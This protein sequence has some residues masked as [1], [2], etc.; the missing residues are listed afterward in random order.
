M[1]R[2]I[3]VVVFLTTVLVGG[4]SAAQGALSN[5]T[6]AQWGCVGA[7]ALD[8]VVCVSNPLPERLPL[9]Q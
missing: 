7:K 8:T 6:A 1:K 3:G 9:P 4:G 5:R 2:R